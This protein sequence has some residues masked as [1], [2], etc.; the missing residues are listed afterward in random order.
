MPAERTRYERDIRPYLVP[1]D[2]AVALTRTD[3]GIQR[4]VVLVR[5]AAVE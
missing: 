5:A 1:F 2:A 4:T 3:G